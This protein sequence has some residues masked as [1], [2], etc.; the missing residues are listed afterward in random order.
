MKKAG[1]P[2]VAGVPPNGKQLFFVGGNQKL[3]DSMLRKLGCDPEKDFCDLGDCCLIEYFAQKK[4][5]K[6][7]PM[8]YYHEFGEDTGTRPRLFY[9]KNPGNVRVG[10]W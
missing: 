9:R 2:D 10:G 8:T 3:D 5:D 1:A 6:Y 4:F 7:E